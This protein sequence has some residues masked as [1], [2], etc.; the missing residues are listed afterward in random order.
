MP[1]A[2]TQLDINVNVSVSKR[3]IKDSDAKNILLVS[4]IG[5]HPNCSPK[6]KLLGAQTL[7]IM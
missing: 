2:S 6:E 4:T 5:I 1:P 3:F 7:A